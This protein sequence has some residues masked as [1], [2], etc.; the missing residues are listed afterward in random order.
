MPNALDAFIDNFVVQWHPE[1]L[2]AKKISISRPRVYLIDFELAIQFSEDCPVENRVCVGLPFGGSFLSPEMYM[3]QCPPE[4]ESG[5]PYDPFKLDVWQLASS[6][7]EFKVL[8]LRPLLTFNLIAFQSK[9]SAIDETLAAMT[10]DDAVCRL[11]AQQALDR[12]GHIVSS[13]P[14]E[15]LLFEPEGAFKFE[16]HTN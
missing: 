15:S 5:R 16:S 10:D 11:D 1:S 2:T 13:M 6:L 9:I 8:G 12:L 14:P 3:R 4:V 7:H